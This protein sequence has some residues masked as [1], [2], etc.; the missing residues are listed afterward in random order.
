[1]AEYTLAKN[2]VREVVI[3]GRAYGMEVGNYTVALEIKEW[4]ERLQAFRSEGGRGMLENGT[5]EDFA[6]K[7]SD[8]VAAAFGEDAARELVGGRNRL[9]MLRILSVLDILMREYASDDVLGEQERAILSFA[10]TADE[11]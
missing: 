4:V 2:P 5:L 7:G 9:N 11:D 6:S 1:M 10:S 8:L 3:D